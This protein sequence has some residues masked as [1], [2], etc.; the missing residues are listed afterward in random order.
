[1]TG[2]VF[3]A[4]LKLEHQADGSAK[5]SFLAEV[6]RTLDSAEGRFREFSDE[7]RR[8]VDTALSA[9]RTKAG[10]LDLGGGY[11]RQVAEAKQARAIAAREIAQATALAAKEEQDYSQATRLAIAATEAHAKEEEQAARAAL[12]HAQAVEQVQERLNRQTSAT[13]ALVNV[14]GRG[15]VS[16]GQYRAGLQQLSYQIGDVA[17]GFALGINPMVIFAQQ[18]QQVIQAI[19]LMRGS[20][21][22]FVG[23]LGG[24]WGAAIT[25]AATVLGAV[26]IP[27]L[28]E[29]EKATKDAEFASFKFGDAQSILGGVID[30]TTGKINTQSEA[31]IAL[32][33]AQAVAGQVEARR[34]QADANKTFRDIR[35]GEVVLSAG[36]GGGLE[37]QRRGDA[38][39]DIVSAFQT[40]DLSVREAERG[41][42]SLL[43]TGLVTEDQYLKAA[44][45]VTAFGVAAENLKVFEQLDKAL[46][47]DKDALGGFLRPPSSRGGKEALSDEEKAYKQRQEAAER[48]IASLSEEIDRIGKGPAELRQLEV[49][50][51]KEAAA[52]DKQREAI[53]NLNIEREAALSDEE[54]RK[55][56]EADRKATE[57]LDAYLREIENEIALMG[58]AGPARQRAALALEEQTFKAK[59]TKDGILDVEAAWAKYLDTRS[60][61]IDARTAMDRDAEAARALSEA[62]GSLIGKVSSLDTTGSAIGGLLGLFSG[63]T[64]SVG[65]PLGELLNQ[66]TGG[67]KPEL[68]SQGRETGRYI[69]RTIGDELRDVFKPSGEFSKAMSEVLK[70]ASTGLIAGNLFGFNGATSQF[71]SAIGGALAGEL[72]DNVSKAIGGALGSVAGAALPIV[73]GIIGGALGSLLSSTPRGSATIGNIGGALGVTGTRGTSQARIAASSKSAEAIIDSLES[74]AEQLGATI[75][76]SLGSVSIGIRKGNYRVDTTGAGR[77]KTSKGAIDFGQDAQAAAYYAMLDLIKDGVLTGI[78]AS[79]Q[80]ILQSGDDLERALQDALDFENVF[81]RLK[82][83]RDPIG[84]ALDDIDAEFKRLESLFAK[85]GASAEEYAQLEELYGIERANAIKEATER[86]TGSLK[87]L[88]SFLNT[89]DAGLSLRDREANAR[90]EYDALAARV[91]AGDSTAY[92][93]F[94]EAARTLLDIERQLYGSQ[95]P[96]FDLTSEVKALTQQALATSTSQIEDAANRD[97]PFTSSSVP[98]NDSAAVSSRIDAMNANLAGILS[99]ELGGQLA[100][101]NQ[102]IGN[103]NQ[104]VDTLVALQRQVVG[105]TTLLSRYQTYF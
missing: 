78:K 43:D 68:D 34:E 54:R 76:A 102:N 55:S 69:A 70:G 103:M 32:A 87:E 94:A 9:D 44:K 65:G 48:Y 59:A 61:E 72:S 57:A 12:S 50:R 58:L 23:F 17:Q 53:E 6:D 46:G 19:T 81:K 3:P 13:T 37:F 56:I 85:A 79:T 39:A 73:G 52:T 25:G 26:L 100:A 101:L 31:L 86:V 96:Y 104:S 8:L 16:A 40:G 7:A 93:D 45:A 27:R 28:F 74:V 30:L 36:F 80:R 95:Q 62:L 63:N 49:A 4:F 20:T 67:V 97:S 84:A 91:R 10:S 66:R 18:S 83:Y 51:A 71:G 60:R 41:L 1:M 89:G 15:T 47:G 33:R 90:T 14:T 22:G 38:T 75:N 42:K 99:N 92:D 11:L 21:G 88:L 105:G 77:T 2:S 24:P 82:A 29:T 64:Q 35:K 5:A 98:T